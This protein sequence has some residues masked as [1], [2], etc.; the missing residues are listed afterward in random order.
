MMIEP[1]AVVFARGTASVAAPASPRPAGL[2]IDTHGSEIGDLLAHRHAGDAELAARAVVALHE[3]AD[4]VASGFASSTR[5]AVPMP[6]LNCG[7]PCRCHRRR[8]P[9]RTGPLVAP[10]SAAMT[11]SALDVEAVDVVEAAVVGLGDDGQPPRLQPGPRDLPLQDGVADDADAVRVGDRDRAL[12][13]SPLSSSQVVPVISPLPLSVNHAG[14]HRSAFW[15]PR[16][17]TTVTPVRTG[18]LPRREVLRRR[19]ASCGR[20]RRRRRR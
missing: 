15:L 7:R 10:S 12:R 9:P 2:G 8:C 17:W 19:S 18:P 1:V 3:H 20:P 6:P 5:D 11:C 14:E 13:G 16:G 4:G